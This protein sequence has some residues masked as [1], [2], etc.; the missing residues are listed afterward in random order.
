[1]FFISDLFSAY[2]G[3]LQHSTL[4]CSSPTSSLKLTMT[5]TT[6]PTSLSQ[7]TQ[8]HTLIPP[9]EF[10]RIAPDIYASCLP[11]PRSLPFLNNLKIRSALF[12]AHKQHPLNLDLPPQVRSWILQLDS[13]KWSPI[14][15]TKG[16][17][18]IAISQTGMKAALEVSMP[19]DD[20]ASIYHC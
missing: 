14:D 18:R 13:H 7:L 4:L 6:W 1:M 3:H 19:S 5:D 11:H 8:T 17:G 12:F 2:Q 16:H 10:V 15:K 20:I 9:R